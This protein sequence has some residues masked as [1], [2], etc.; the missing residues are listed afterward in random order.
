MGKKKSNRTSGSENVNRSPVIADKTPR[1]RKPMMERVKM[2]IDL[3]S[4][5]L[6]AL[7]KMGTLVSTGEPT[8]DQV[9]AC[10]RI[11]MNLQSAQ[12]MV[13]QLA[14][15]VKLLLTSGFIPKASAPGRK[16]LVAG[17]LVKIKEAKFDV[18]MHG[19]SNHFEVVTTSEKGARIQGVEDATVQFPVLRAWLEADKA[20]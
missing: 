14:A 10:E 20:S 4:K 11:E 7:A 17:D 1:V 19:D 18:A 2:N 15:D 6:G 8:V 9:A 13:A 3:A 12:S 16:G 5:K